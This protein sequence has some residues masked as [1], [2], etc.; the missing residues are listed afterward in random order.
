MPLSRL[1]TA[2]VV[3]GQRTPEVRFTLEHIG[4]TDVVRL[5]ILLEIAE[6][7]L[8]LVTSSLSMPG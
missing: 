5:P 6:R 3:S 4:V 1:H 2:D 8:V 7:A